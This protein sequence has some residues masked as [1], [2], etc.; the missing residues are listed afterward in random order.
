MTVPV[1]GRTGPA[2]RSNP[3]KSLSPFQ[4]RTVSDAGQIRKQAGVPEQQRYGKVSR[5]SEYVPQQRGVEVWP[6][7]TTCIG[8]RHYEEG[9]PY[10]THMPDGEL[11]GAHNGENGHGFRGTVYTG[12]PAL[13]EQ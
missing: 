7:R 5:Y 1:F 12:T 13:A 3:I 10:T 2:E 11:T 4:L 6:E 9:H 8:I